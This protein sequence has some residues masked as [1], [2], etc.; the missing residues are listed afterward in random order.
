MNFI[1]RKWKTNLH[2]ETG[3]SLGHGLCVYDQKRKR[4]S[5]L[6]GFVEGYEWYHGKSDTVV[7]YTIEP[8]ATTTTDILE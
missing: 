7:I 4:G 6:I 2:P 1:W 5:R 3:L 8:D